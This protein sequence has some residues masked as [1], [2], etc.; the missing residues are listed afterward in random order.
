MASGTYLYSENHFRHRSLAARADE[1]IGASLV[2]APSVRNDGRL[3][4]SPAPEKMMSARSATAVR[5]MSAKFD[6]ATM[7][8]TPTM[9]RVA[10]RA[11]RS[12]CFSPQTE[13]SR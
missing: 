12:S 10:S 11:L 9:P 8:F 2:F 4:G 5:T 3:S 7:T 1:T 6:M 13:A